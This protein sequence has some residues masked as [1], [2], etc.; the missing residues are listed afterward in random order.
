MQVL[1][2]LV[3]SNFCVVVVGFMMVSGGM[4]DIVHVFMLVLLWYCWFGF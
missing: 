4:V 1:L 2:R 3:L